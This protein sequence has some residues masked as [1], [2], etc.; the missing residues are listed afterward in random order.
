MKKAFVTLVAVI[1]GIT[2]SA[3]E[4]FVSPEGS[5]LWKGTAEEPFRTISKAAEIAVAGDTVTVRKG[6]YREWVTPKNGGANDLMRIL[7]RAYEGE[8]VH[9]KGSE[10]ITDWKKEKGSV[11]KATIDNDFFGKFNPYAKVLTGDWCASKNRVHLG[12]VYSEGKALAEVY[13]IDSLKTG[14]WFCSV[15]DENTCIWAD[16]GKVNPNRT[17]TEINVRPACFFPEY[18]GVNYITVRGFKMSQAATWWAPPT[19]MQIGLVGPHWSKGW[20]IEDNEIFHSKASGISLGKERASAENPASS[21]KGKVGFFRQLEAVFNAEALGW[22]K[23]LIGSHIIR[24]NIIHDCGQTGIVGHMGC[25]FSTISDNYIYDINTNRDIAGAEIA[26]IKVHAAIDVLIERNIIINTYK[27]IWLDWQAQGTRVTRNIIAE[28]DHRDIFVEVSHGP[29]MIDNNILLSRSA[30][31]FAAKGTAVVHNLISGNIEGSLEVDRYTPYHFPHS[32]KIAGVMVTAGGDHRFYNNIFLKPDTLENHRGVNHYDGFPPFKDNYMYFRNVKNSQTE[33][34]PPVASC[35]NLFINGYGAYKHE[36]GSAYDT[37]SRNP[38]VD[39]SVEN[40][41]IYITLNI[42][43][44]SG[45]L[46][47]N[48]I[49][50]TELLGTTFAS[51]SL[52]EN[53]DETRLSVDID[54]LGEKRSETPTAG[55]FEKVMTGQKIKVWEFKAR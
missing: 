1:A 11:W 38:S 50:T 12:E 34:I 42:N 35:N 44:Y 31:V 36:E 41:G 29:T 43:D 32:T 17:L 20:I 55:P 25:A 18:S 14:T 33:I 19:A 4:Y 13:D 49:I 10:Q 24:R 47:N 51:E 30:L 5:D 21:R 37:T 23:E 46:E 40:D 54:L 53:R 9:I 7:Y 45:V 26:G 15:D 39:L 6:V 8:E 3:R 27:G 28:S 22:C 16:F 52:F 2:S 48:K